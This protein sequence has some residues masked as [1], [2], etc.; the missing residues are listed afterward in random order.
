[1][2][3][4][5]S[6]HGDGWIHVLMQAKSH[7]LVGPNTTRFFSQQDIGTRNSGLFPYGIGMTTGAVHRQC[8]VS[9]RSGGDRFFRS[10]G[11]VIGTFVIDQFPGAACVAYV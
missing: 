10:P 7:R 6:I 9:N 8:C 2:H 5:L 4:T 3:L 11:T 1:M